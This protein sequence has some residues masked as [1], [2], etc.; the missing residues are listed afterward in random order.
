MVLGIVSNTLGQDLA[1][2]MLWKVEGKH[3]KTSYLFGTIHMLPKADFVLKEKV[4][5]AFSESESLTL[6]LDITAPG[7]QL[8]VMQYAMMTDGHTVGEYLADSTYVKLD[9]TLKASMG[10]GL[11]MVQ[12]MKPFVISTFLIGKYVGSEPASFE[13]T[14]AEM[15]M[16][17]SIPIFG[18]ETMQEQMAVFDSIPYQSQAN[19][20]ADMVWDES[21]M[22]GMYDEMVV[23]YKKEEV[24]AL[25]QMLEAEMGDDGS[26]KFL[27]DNRNVKWIPLIENQIKS[28]NCFIAV[29]AGH[30]AGDMGVIA[31]LRAAGYKVTPVFD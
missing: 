20:L 13:T 30:L 10:M 12:T 11:A 6:E 15:A 22:Q 23:A 9:E 28:Q 17:D 25:G 16:S 7:M 2:S 5:T 1:N 4:K 24:T 14:L 21:D 26:D 8:Q 3:V 29:G 19:D 18:L 27:L 31:L